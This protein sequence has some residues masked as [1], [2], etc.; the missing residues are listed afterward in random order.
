MAGLCPGHPR[1]CSP[2][3]RKKDVD[4]RDKR[5]HDCEI[6]GS[7]DRNTLACW[8]LDTS[9]L[10]ELCSPRPSR[11][12]ASSLLKKADYCDRINHT[13]DDH[14]FDH[15]HTGKAYAMAAVLKYEEAEFLVPMDSFPVRAEKIP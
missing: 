4:A 6:N 11:R 9:I 7:F 3:C 5:G 8:L 10:S 1:L 15:H 2:G 13:I 12:S 14:D